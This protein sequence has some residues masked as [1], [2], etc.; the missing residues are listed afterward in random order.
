MPTSFGCRACQTGIED[1]RPLV[2]IAHP[3]APLVGGDKVAA[4]KA[5]N[6]EAQLLEHGD[7]LGA[8]PVEVI[9]RHQR[10]CTDVKLARAGARD[11]ERGVVAGGVGGVAQG[12]GAVTRG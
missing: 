7:H 1:G 6:A 5:Q 4:R 11:L 8:K 3:V 9:G 10:H 12:V 2:D